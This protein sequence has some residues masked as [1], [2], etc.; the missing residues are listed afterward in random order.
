M[1]EIYIIF[2]AVT[3]LGGKLILFGMTNI[4]ITCTMHKTLQK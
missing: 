2:L 4:D 1:F 3:N